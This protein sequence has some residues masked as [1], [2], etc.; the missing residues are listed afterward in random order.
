VRVV[1]TGA[2]GFIGGQVARALADAGHDV[3]AVDHLA[4]STAPRAAQTTWT[5]LDRHP[6]ITL[7]EADLTVD[8]LTKPAEADAVVHLAGRPGV[9][10][11]FGAGAAATERDNVEATRRLL[12]ACTG[13]PRFVLASS[14]SVYGSAPRPS[15]ETDEPRPASPYARSKVRAERLALSSGLPVTVLR[16]FSV[17]GPGQRPDMAFHRFIEAARAGSP[18]PV[19]G[20]GLQSRAFTYVGDVVA[21]TV[22]AATTD[23]PPGTILNIG[24]DR[25]EPLAHAIALLGELIGVRQR[26]DHRP[27]AP[28][29]TPRTW[30]DPTRAEDLLGWR[31]TTPLAA[32]LAAQ[33]A[34]HRS[35]RPAA[36]LM[37]AS[38]AESG[39]VAV[40]GGSRHG[41]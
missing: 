5:A 23:L 28:G 40:S 25:P 34:W 30:A 24:H 32:G 4:H 2:A 29:D 9:R 20:A 31:A 35:G 14:S 36:P 15:R 7:I 16:Y 11:S 8:D 13:R 33:L 10:T 38:E 22:R 39:G 37:S 41:R 18:L 19:L 12:A 3:L 17:Y 26:V 1:V 27:P 6:G 21:A